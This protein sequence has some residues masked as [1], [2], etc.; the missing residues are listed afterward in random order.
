MER[1]EALRNMA[2]SI[3]G[4]MLLPGCDI[5]RSKLKPQEMGPLSLS[6]LQDEALTEAVDTFIPTTDTPGAVDLNV[7]NFIQK[8][9][10]DCYEKEEQEE[11]IKGL[12]LL[13]DQAKEK[14]GT[15]IGTC[16]KEQRI[17]LL[18][19]FEQSEEELPKKF[20]SR[21]KELTI[22]GYTTSEYVMTNLTNYTMVPGHY[23]GC[24]PV[25]DKKSS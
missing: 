22:L 2:L 12:S 20:Y 23:Y 10:A 4:L 5:G 7:H 6:P 14:C 16:S 11:F 18:A 15:S 1:R 8:I 9:M 17:D 13:Q 24:V 25:T 21:L 19:S 3:W